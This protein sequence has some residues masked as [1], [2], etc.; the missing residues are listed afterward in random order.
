MLQSERDTE[1]YYQA[2]AK[3]EQRQR[4]ID[5]GWG[6]RAEYEKLQ[7]RERKNRHIQNI[8]NAILG[9]LMALFIAVV[10]FGTSY[11]TQGYPI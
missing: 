6:D 1:K 5:K 9:G 10:I 8:K 2:Q 4:M 3:F 11:L 7:H